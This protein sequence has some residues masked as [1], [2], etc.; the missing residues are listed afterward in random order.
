[1]RASPL[2]AAAGVLGAA[3]LTLAVALASPPARP[4]AGVLAAL[5]PFPLLLASFHALRELEE[6]P[7]HTR[8][9]RR[10]L[11]ALLL[12]L[13]TLV[14]LAAVAQVV[15]VPAAWRVWDRLRPGHPQ[16]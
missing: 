7:R 11:L 13:L 1:V 6:A 14:P 9:R 4:A 16:P 12:N 2:G 5:L 10:L 3:L 8:Q 15:G